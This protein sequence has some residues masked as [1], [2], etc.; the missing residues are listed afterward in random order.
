MSLAQR[1][2]SSAA[3]DLRRRT[4]AVEG[5]RRLSDG[6]TEPLTLPRLLGPLDGALAVMSLTMVLIA[7]A[8]L[9]ARL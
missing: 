1:R 3:R 6:S 8:L 2:L 7:A 9:A 5:V 4:V